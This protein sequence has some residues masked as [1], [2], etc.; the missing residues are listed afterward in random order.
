MC[1][2]L[3]NQHWYFIIDHY[4]DVN[5]FV[6]LLV[7]FSLLIAFPFSARGKDKRTRY[8]KSM[9]NKAKPVLK[10]PSASLSGNPMYSLFPRTR[11]I[12][13]NTKRSTDIP[14]P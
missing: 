6:Q 12:S 3:N 8:A 11:G 9:G 4:F 7:W 1:L 2:L 5:T 10:F 13:H 14:F